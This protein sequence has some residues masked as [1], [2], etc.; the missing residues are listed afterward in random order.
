M[1]RSAS[2]SEREARAK[3]KARSDRAHDRYVQRTYGLAPGQYK[4]MLEAQDGRCAMCRRIPRSKRL[5]VDHD[6][7]TGKVRGLLCG[8]CNHTILGMLEFDA[9]AAYHASVYIAQIAEDTAQHQLR[10]RVEM[11]HK[12][13][14]EKQGLKDDDLPF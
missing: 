2:P 6:H 9:I 8:G 5:A 12:M 3:E 11:V 10:D 4:E 13:L 7:F 14:D 1:R